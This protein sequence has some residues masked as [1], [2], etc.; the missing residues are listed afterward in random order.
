ME[1]EEAAAMRAQ[2]AALTEELARREAEGHVNH[3]RFIVAHV[4]ALEA[5]L[6]AL[7]IEVREELDIPDLIDR[8]S[9]RLTLTAAPALRGLNDP[10][11]G[12]N[13]D[14]VDSLASRLGEA[15]SGRNSRSEKAR[16][17]ARPVT[18]P[19]GDDGERGLSRASGSRRRPRERFAAAGRLC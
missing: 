12:R 13:A 9:A 19:P 11:S 14:A 3:Q 2:I 6:I 7:A 10:A 17:R 8:V 18:V 5:A 4:Q 16:P 1:K 15:E